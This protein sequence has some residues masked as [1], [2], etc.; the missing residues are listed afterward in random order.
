MIYT[1]KIQRAIKFSAKTHNHY[2]QQTRKGKVIPYIA[3]PLTVGIILSLANAPEDVIVAGILH[4]TIEDSIEEKKVTA[5]MLEE[6]FG[7]NVAE[8]V[9]SVTEI[10]RS[11]PWA[12]RKSIA[13]SHVKDFSFESALL[14]SADVL[15][16]VSEILDDFQRY[17]LDVFKHFTATPKETLAVYVKMI[18]ALV[19]RFPENP[20]QEDLKKLLEKIDVMKIE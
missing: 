20:L 1:E 17:G 3:H 11:L 2:Q 16:N 6:R 19:A 10:D 13:L 15:S 12:E 18:N 4:D 7:K 9:L 5:Q 8:L 14:K